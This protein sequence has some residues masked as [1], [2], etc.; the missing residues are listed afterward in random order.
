MVYGGAGGWATTGTEGVTE[1]SR[2]KEDG[3]RDMKEKDMKEKLW[4]KE[5]EER[6][7]KEEGVRGRG[8]KV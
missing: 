3:E 8:E 2:M 7:M 1:Y 5:Y 4:R 6:G